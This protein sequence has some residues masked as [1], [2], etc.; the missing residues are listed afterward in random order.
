MDWDGLTRMIREEDG[1]G[2]A[3]TLMDS[4]VGQDRV[5]AMNRDELV[6][7]LKPILAAWNLLP[8][9]ILNGMTPVEDFEARNPLPEDDWDDEEDATGEDWG[10]E[11]A[12][13]G[14]P[15]PVGPGDGGDIEG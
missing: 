15:L 3:V 6:H 10:D 2:S 13:A 12:E 9:D 5:D 1:E 14:E 4:I 8:H 7:T 11:P